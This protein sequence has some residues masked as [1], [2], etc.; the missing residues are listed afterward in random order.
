METPY[1]V[2]KYYCCYVAHSSDLLLQEKPLGCVE[3]VSEGWPSPGEVQLGFQRSPMTPVTS[4]LAHPCKATPFQTDLSALRIR[5]LLSVQVK[6]WAP[7][8]P[9][10]TSSEPGETKQAE[11]FREDLICADEL[12]FTRKFHIFHWQAWVEIILGL[13][14][15]FKSAKLPLTS[16]LNRLSSWAK[17]TFCFYG[18]W[19]HP[20]KCF[21]LQHTV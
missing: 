5:M 4:C 19:K 7:E 14:I 8:C 15:T 13:L 21:A 17:V 20:K 12:R 9:G 3:G 1:L 16:Q 11:I 18:N 6:L 10:L 2:K